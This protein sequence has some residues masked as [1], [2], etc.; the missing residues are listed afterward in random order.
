MLA[1]EN[2]LGEVMVSSATVGRGSCFALQIDGNSMKNADMQDGDFVIVHRQQL[3]EN[4]DIVVALIDDEATVKRLSIEDGK[5]RL[6]PENRRYRPIEVSPRILH[7]QNERRE[8]RSADTSDSQAT[9]ESSRLQY[10]GVSPWLRHRSGPRR[11]HR[12]L[13]TVAGRR[14]R[15]T[16]LHVGVLILLP[17][18]CRAK[19]E[20]RPT[21]A[22]A[23]MTSPRQFSSP[24]SGTGFH[25]TNQRHGNRRVDRSTGSPD[26][27]GCVICV[28]AGHV[29]LRCRSKFRAIGLRKHG[30]HSMRYPGGGDRS[31]VIE[32]LSASRPVTA[33]HMCA[34]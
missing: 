22:D 32:S 34:S 33:H 27:G 5:I 26:H 7:E 21:V 13:P 12:F 19:H 20:P 6:L 31:C 14:S 8:L 23:T 4:G 1:E 30:F 29:A 2:C 28:V 18:I 25:R 17:S 3:A 11:C 24:T 15:V 10:S 16:V 9:I